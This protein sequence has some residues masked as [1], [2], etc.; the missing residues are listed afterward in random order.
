MSD[1][2]LLTAPKG[3]RIELGEIIGKNVW[4]LVGYVL[5][6]VICIIISQQDFADTISVELLA[7]AVIGAG[8]LGLKFLLMAVSSLRS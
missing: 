8:F 5:G 4:E 2:S 7:G 3:S 1:Y 6:I